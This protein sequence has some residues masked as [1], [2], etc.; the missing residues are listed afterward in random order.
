M[1]LK[2]WIDYK[3]LEE[4]LK[5]LNANEIERNWVRPE[6]P[7]LSEGNS[8]LDIE[9]F[10]NLGHELQ[11]NNIINIGEP[12]LVD[13][14][15][16]DLSTVIL[17]RRKYK[18]PSNRAINGKFVTTMIDDCRALYGTPLNGYWKIP[19]QFI[20][21]LIKA[22]FRCSVM[23]NNWFVTTSNRKIPNGVYYIKHFWC[24]AT[25]EPLT[26]NNTEPKIGDVVC[27]VKGSYLK[28]VREN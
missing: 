13:A 8:I 2:Y 27:D 22:K 9:Y 1:K 5:S 16:N 23:N 7:K 12:F 18:L 6:N 4:Y 14:L 10:N 26:I 3:G 19:S 20:K 28:I 21:P 25:E 17:S 11:K 24:Y 15:G